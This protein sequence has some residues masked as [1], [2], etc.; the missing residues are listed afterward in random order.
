MHLCPALGYA[1]RLQKLVLSHCNIP[2]GGLVQVAQL[3]GLAGS[4]QE[5]CIDRCTVSNAELAALP[6]LTQLTK[7]SAV[8]LSPKLGNKQAL[9]LAQMRSLQVLCVRSNDLGNK[10]LQVLAKGLPAL[11]CLDAGDNQRVSK[12]C[13]QQLAPLLERGAAAAAREEIEPHFW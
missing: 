7:L 11:V 10:G 5:L 12:R 9:L 6:G 1:S 8:A 13:A 4:L 2:K 3:P